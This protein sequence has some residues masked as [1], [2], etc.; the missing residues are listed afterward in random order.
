M[1]TA[2]KSRNGRE[3][4]RPKMT[5]EEARRFDRLSVAS[6]AQVVEQ[7]E[8]GCEPYADIY[9]FNRWRA[10]GFH[11]VKGEKAIK[12]SSWVPVETADSK[13]AEEG[14]EEGETAGRGPRLLPR[15]LSVFCRHQVEA[16]EAE[17]AR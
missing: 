14:A 5:A 11:V 9:T 6:Y 12:F 16:N 4:R 8:C 15:T 17:T 10:L 1:S 3:S 13:R 7:L 2:T